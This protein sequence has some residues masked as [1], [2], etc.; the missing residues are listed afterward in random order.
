[1]S[2]QGARGFSLG[3]CTQ[4]FRAGL[5]TLILPRSRWLFHRRLHRCPRSRGIRDLGRSRCLSAQTTAHPALPPLQNSLFGTTFR[6]NIGHSTAI[7]CTQTVTISSIINNLLRF[8]NCTTKTWTDLR[9][10]RVLDAGPLAG[11]L[12]FLPHVGFVIERLGMF[13]VFRRRNLEEIGVVILSPGSRA[14]R[15]QSARDGS[16]NFFQ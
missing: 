10:V 14:L 7:D 16:N 5:I 6:E 12:T 13:D 1:M 9:L 2:P 11:W 4:R 8:L 15:Q 3:Q